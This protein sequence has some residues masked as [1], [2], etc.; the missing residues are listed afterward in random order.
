MNRNDIKQ[1]AYAMPVFNPSYPRGPFKFVD[2]EFLIIKYETDIEALRAVV[3]EP[4]EVV[5]PY[6]NF[7][8][9]SMPDSSGFGSYTESGQVIPVLYEGQPGNYVHSMYLDDV[10]PILGGREIWGF[11]KK[12]A[13]P[14]LSIGGNNDTLVGTLDYGDE[15]VATATMG[16]KYESL[17]PDAI[18]KA[19]Q[20]QNF[21]LKV[22]PHVDGSTRVCE[23]VRYYMK[24][25]TL[26]GAWSGPADLDF[27]AHALAPLSALPVKKVVSGVHLVSDLTLDF[28]EVVVDYLK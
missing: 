3:P 8:V 23:L 19:M 11:P 14:S 15:R 17:D 27:M 10:S 7:E 18:L 6:V 22:L 28:G 2:R 24:D 21:L 1:N 20:M 12:F 4:L 25:I 5:E 26:K 13:H 9:I 16:Y